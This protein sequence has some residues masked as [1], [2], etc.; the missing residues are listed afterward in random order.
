ME[1]TRY[2][3]DGKYLSIRYPDGTIWDILNLDEVE[4]VKWVS[5]WPRPI[6]NED[7]G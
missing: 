6:N 4:Y 1:K 5:A 3:K 7:N 2:F